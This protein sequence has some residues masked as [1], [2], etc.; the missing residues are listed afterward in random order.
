MCIRDRDTVALEFSADGWELDVEKLLSEL[1]P[2]TKALYL[3][4]PNNPTGWSVTGE[5]QRAILEHCR[6]HGIWIFADD[7]YERLY[8]EAGGVAVSYTH[9]TLPTSDLV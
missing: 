7:A 9:L 3:N 4:S 1:K 8:F 5:Q 6:R 2:G